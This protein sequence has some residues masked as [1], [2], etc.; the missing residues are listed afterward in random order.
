MADSD[1]VMAPA[2]A[3]AGDGGAAGAGGGRRAAAAAYPRRRGAADC[4]LPAAAVAPRPRRA[5]SPADAQ[6]KRKL[7]TDITNAQEGASQSKKTKKEPKEKVAF[8]WSA[9]DMASDVAPSDAMIVSVARRQVYRIT[10]AI[11]ATHAPKIK[12]ATAF[13]SHAGSDAAEAVKARR[14]GAAPSAAAGALKVPPLWGGISHV[15]NAPSAPVGIVGGVSKKH[16]VA[17][18]LGDDRQARLK[19][20]RGKGKKKTK[21]VSLARPF[22]M[23]R[24]DREDQEATPWY[25]N[26]N[27]AYKSCLLRWPNVAKDHADYVTT[28]MTKEM[29]NVMQGKSARKFPPG[30]GKDVKVTKWKLALKCEE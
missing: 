16:V 27:D 28:K 9:E 2:D 25:T 8:E 6:P 26:S 18:A 4:A 1:V 12:R 22:Q 11:Q 20:A 10:T 13:S 5:R 23:W 15:E 21:G 7:G 17:A 24:G 19:E 29:L 14:S 30:V 3:R